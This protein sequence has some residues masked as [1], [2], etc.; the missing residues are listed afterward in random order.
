MRMFI[1]CNRTRAVSKKSSY[2]SSELYFSFL[3]LKAPG[4]ITGITFRRKNAEVERSVR[5]YADDGCRYTPQ[6][7]EVVL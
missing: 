3:S 1:I 4:C 7:I 6:V 2:N 5:T